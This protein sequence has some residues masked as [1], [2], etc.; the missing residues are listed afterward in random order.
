LRL[1]FPTILSCDI[2]SPYFFMTTI[3]EL[4]TRPSRLAWRRR[5]DDSWLRGPWLHGLSPEDE[6]SIDG[7]LIN[8]HQVELESRLHAA[9]DR[10]DKLVAAVRESGSG[11]T[12]TCRRDH[13]ISVVGVTTEVG[14]QGRHFR[15]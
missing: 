9:F 14:F 12:R 10:I 13:S 4:H 3:R 11:T 7:C 6:A 1:L 8:D 2:A 5:D 15:F